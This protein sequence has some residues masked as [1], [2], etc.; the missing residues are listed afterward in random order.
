MPFQ[1][2]K[3]PGAAAVQVVTSPVSLR[4]ISNGYVIATPT[5]GVR[6]TGSCGIEPTEEP[7]YSTVTRLSSPDPFK[8]GP[9][10]PADQYSNPDCQCS[11]SA[12]SEYGLDPHHPPAYSEV[13]Q[14]ST[15]DPQRL[16][17]VQN[18]TPASSLAGYTDVSLLRQV[19]CA[20]I[21]SPTNESQGSVMPKEE[22]Q[23]GAQDGHSDN[24]DGRI[25][26]IDYV[27]ISFLI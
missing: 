11:F 7:G 13:Q 9:Q 21:S 3:K 25:S 12:G 26:S 8:S 24:S 17:K 2:S 22:S 20:K 4:Q 1:E 23:L 15:C 6:R 14:S 5:P 27:N 19:V 16:N 18:C 10:S